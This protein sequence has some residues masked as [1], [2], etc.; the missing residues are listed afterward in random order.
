VRHTGMHFD[1]LFSAEHFRHYKP[2]LEVYRGAVA[3]LGL[4]PHEVTL[5]AAHNGDL[6]VARACGLGTAFVARPREYGPH[7][8]R[9]L[10]PDP[11]IERTARDLLELAEQ[12]GA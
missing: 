8:A 1:V 7:Q 11:E 6:Q 3:L 9:D 2:D 4:E 10:A 12:A 5:V